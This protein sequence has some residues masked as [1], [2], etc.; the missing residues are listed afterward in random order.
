LPAIAL[1]F[2]LGILSYHFIAQHIW[3]ILVVL[4]FGLVKY[5]QTLFYLFK[6]WL[7]FL[8]GIFWIWAYITWQNV[9]TLPVSLEGVPITTTGYVASIPEKQGSRTRFLLETDHFENPSH[10]FLH[11]GLIRCTWENA[12][13]L[14]VGDV[15][16]VNLKLKKPHSPLNPGGFD[17]EAWLFSHKIRAT[18]TIQSHSTPTH[19]G[20]AFFSY[21]IDRLRQHLATKIDTVLFQSQTKGLVKALIIGDQSSILVSQ[22]NVLRA[23]GTNHLFAIAGL[24]I[25]FIAHLVY[26]LTTWQVKR[27]ALHLRAPA[28]MIGAISALCAALLYSALAGFSLPTKRALIMLVIFLIAKIRRCYINAWQSWSF[29]LTLLMLINPLQILTESFWLSFT[30]VGSLIYGFQGRITTERKFMSKVIHGIRTQWITSIA[31]IPLSLLLFQQASL[32]GFFAN[33]IASPWIG[34]LV[35]PIALAGGILILAVPPLGNLLIQIAD[36]LLRHF[37]PILAAMGSSANTQWYQVILTPWVLLSGSIAIL[38]LLAPKGFPS[39]SLAVF[40]ILPLLF[41]KQKNPNFGEVDFTLLDVG[42]GLSSVIRTSHHT[43]VFDTGARFKNFFDAGESIILPFLRFLHVDHLDLLMISHGDNDHIGGA[44]SLLRNLPVHRIITSVPERFPHLSVITCAAGQHWRWDG[45]NF[46]VLYPA[47]GT[48]FKGNNR[49][50]VL[51]ITT[52]THGLLLTGDI[53][54]EAEH[55]LLNTQLKKL[56]ADV[57]VAPHHGSKTSSTE[58]FIQAISPQVVLFPVGYKN[59]YHLPSPLIVNRYQAMGVKTYDSVHC[60][61]IQI[62]LSRAEHFPI[63]CYREEQAFHRSFFSPLRPAGVVE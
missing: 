36:F 33:F 2:F 25:G 52:K 43:L 3:L 26:H 16:R 34:F 13:A 1:P 51:K 18:G 28:Q 27:K 62:T 9:W 42:Q 46:E 23:T 47:L 45:V 54:K 30:A 17:Y 24:H 7:I 8:S 11:T 29:A 10:Y 56:I 58:A 4:G 38:L 55:I 50:C 53:E 12:P 41:C 48:L 5:Q 57:L 39:R 22:W 32:V 6:F 44:N 19:V 31:L 49:S 60:G 35:A 37:W 59:Q 15:W 21:P 61:A 20:T 63:H 14:H 40:F